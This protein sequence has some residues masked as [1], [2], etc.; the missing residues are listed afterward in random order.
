MKCKICGKDDALENF[1][2]CYTGKDGD[3][4]CESLNELDLDDVAEVRDIEHDDVDCLNTWQPT[5]DD[6]RQAQQLRSL[7]P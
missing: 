2:V 7:T 3:F 4:D 5:I 6:L 1:T